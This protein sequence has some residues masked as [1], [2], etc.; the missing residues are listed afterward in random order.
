[1]VNAI[2]TL[3]NVGIQHVFGFLAKSFGVCVLL[4]HRHVERLDKFSF[5]AYKPCVPT[6]ASSLGS[7]PP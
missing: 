2:K 6:F 3:G 5:G 4:L 7:I 1:M